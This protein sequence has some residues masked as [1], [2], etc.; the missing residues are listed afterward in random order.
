MINQFFPTRFFFVFH[1][2]LI[3]IITNAQVIPNNQDCLGA[4][5]VCGSIYNQTNSFTGEGHVLNEINAGSS[6]LSSGEKNDVWYTF[7]VQTSGNLNFTIT[8]NNLADDYDWALFNLTNATCSQIYTNPALQVSCNYS[9]TTGLTGPN[10]STTLSTQGAGGTPF[11][12]V[13]PVTAGQTYVLNISHF[14]TSQSGYTFD[15]GA[16]T[17]TIFDNV[18]PHPA[19]VVSTPV[20]AALACGQNKITL[21]FSENVLCGDL[22]TMD[23]AISGP[24]VAHKITKVKCVST[25]LY[26]NSFDLSVSP[27]I[28]VGGNYKVYLTRFRTNKLKDLC[29]NAGSSGVALASDTVSFVVKKIASN[30]SKL[31]INCFGDSSGLAKITPSNGTTPYTYSWNT[32]PAQTTQAISKLPI[33]TYICKVIDSKGCPKQDTIVLAQNPPFVTTHGTFQDTCG[34]GTGIAFVTASGGKK[35]YTFLWDDATNPNFTPQTNDTATLLNAGTYTI[36]IADSLLCDTTYAITVISPPKAL[37]A[38]TYEPRT[39]SLFFP[40]CYFTDHSQ[41]AV[42]W[43]WDF[44][45]GD[46]SALQN[47]FHK[48]ESDSTFPVKLV[49]KNSWGCKDSSIVNI[50]VDGFYTI[51]IPTSFTPNG[52][53]KNDIFIPKG[54]GLFPGKYELVIYARNGQAIYKTNDIEKGWDGR[55]GGNKVQEDVYVFNLTFMDYKFKVHTKT[56]AI[57]MGR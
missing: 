8:P 36:T 21:K 42:S 40:D 7:T 24:G 6:C 23:L 25:G 49:T 38:F 50:L 47:P 28:T 54:S 30:K 43:H 11:N 16:T 52:D 55:V 56:G 10:G 27:P 48:F 44:G 15:L 57:T 35:P 41:N 1:L 22:D 5:P 29:G 33:G 39:L 51:Y 26:S 9:L 2:I 46:T 14:T 37:P 45:D 13:V 19:S 12:K 20:G 3:S 32:V 18:A 53:G 34:T 31:D 4:I 17:A